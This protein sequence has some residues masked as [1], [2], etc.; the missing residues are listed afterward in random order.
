M[1]IL[2]KSYDNAHKMRDLK[3]QSLETSG[4]APSIY[5]RP[6]ADSQMPA[7][8]DAL[9]F[10]GFGMDFG[11]SWSMHGRSGMVQAYR[12]VNVQ[13]RPPVEIS[14]LDVARTF[15]AKMLESLT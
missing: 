7:I 5:H 8:L 11:P 10:Y 15:T 1:V 13:A 4:G 3:K 2:T 12:A 14:E 9:C 6:Y